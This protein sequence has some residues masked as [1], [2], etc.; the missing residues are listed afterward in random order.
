M[1][2]CPVCDEELTAPMVMCS[3]C[4]TQAHRGCSKKRVGKW[5]C[6][7]FFKKAKK[8]VQY[9]KMSRRAQTFGGKSG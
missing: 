7:D 4:D 5:Y 3:K 9:E 1:V 8:V 2:D 6:K